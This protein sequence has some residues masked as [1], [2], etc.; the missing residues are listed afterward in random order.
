MTKRDAVRL[1]VDTIAAQLQASEIED[2]I[3]ST[4]GLSDADIDRI[5]WA[6]DYVEGRIRKIGGRNG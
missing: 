6:M 1:V 5:G 4:Y 2:L 3:G